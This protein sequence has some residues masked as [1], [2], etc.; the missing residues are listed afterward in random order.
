MLPKWLATDLVVYATPLYNYAMT[1][2][3]KAF[4]ERTLPAMEPFFE[5]HEGPGFR[6]ALRKRYAKIPFYGSSNHHL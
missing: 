3:P 4:I 2:T 1:A 5:I 6:S